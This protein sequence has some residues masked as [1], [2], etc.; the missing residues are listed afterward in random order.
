MRD[1]DGRSL[2]YADNE[3]E[4]YAPDMSWM[5]DGAAVRAMA[6]NSTPTV[7]PLAAQIRDGLLHTAAV[8]ALEPPPA[9]V[10]G[11]LY[12]DSLSMLYGPSGV[13]KTFLAEDFALHTAHG[14]W[15]QG[16]EVKAGRVLYVIA[17]GA[18]GFGTR[19][20]AWEK[21]H[22]LHT[23]AHP[24]DWLPWAVNVS[25]PAWAAALAEVVAEG[26]YCLVVLD[27]FARC[28]VGA[29]ENSARD[30]GIIV[31]NLDQIRRASGA[32]VLVVHHSG[33]DSAAGAR[34]SSALRAAM[35]TELELTGDAARLVLHS[36]KQKD[37]PEAA[38]ILL[39]LRSV[40]D[41]V[42]IDRAGDDD[43]DNLP[44]AAVATLEALQQIDVPGGVSA[45][46][47]RTSADVA[48]RSFYRHRT[49]LLNAGLV[50]NVGTDKQPRYKPVTTGVSDV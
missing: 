10:A 7:N 27:T 5:D 26:G 29:E 9:L 32:C 1:P 17:E 15:W 41:S 31:A 28:S 11:L 21:H 39:A 43:P 8:K 46:A 36:R 38:P 40:G 44:A 49:G 50:V 42:V 18:S 12:A 24:V 20:S 48:E 2:A 33:K 16:R 4:D 47:W 23:E 37:A 25:N 6:P 22:G 14:S 13:G 34:G 45:T 30:V 3:L 19:V 35:T